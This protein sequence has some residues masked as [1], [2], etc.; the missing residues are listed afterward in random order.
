MIE[1]IVGYCRHHNTTKLSFAF[2]FD[3]ETEPTAT[4]KD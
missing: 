4:P 2:S 1:Q 3:D